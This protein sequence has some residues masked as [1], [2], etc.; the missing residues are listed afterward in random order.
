MLLNSS[1]RQKK[2]G[3]SACFCGTL[4]RRDALKFNELSLFKSF[5]T[6]LTI[7]KNNVSLK[8]PRHPATNHVRK[9]Y[10]PTDT[11]PGQQDVKDAPQLQQYLQGR[12]KGIPTV[13]LGSIHNA[14]KSRTKLDH[15]T[16]V[17]GGCMFLRKGKE[18]KN[19][20]I[21]IGFP[22]RGETESREEMHYRVKFKERR[23][24]ESNS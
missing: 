24:K 20:G 18:I 12:S 16:S 22:K 9:P 13:Q 10:A 6:S 1:F 3:G 14:N 7:R 2:A 23:N 8:A 19:T 5:K 21:G 15:R 4:T 11:T 17:D